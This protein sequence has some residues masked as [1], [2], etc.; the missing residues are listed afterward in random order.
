MTS[1]PPKV[2]AMKIV[3]DNDHD[4]LSRGLFA[5]FWVTDK[6]RYGIYQTTFGIAGHFHYNALNLWH[7][8]LIPCLRSRTEQAR[9]DYNILFLKGSSKFCK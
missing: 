2:L 4:Y 7:W 6:L 5:P 8:D 1:F 3:W 9:L